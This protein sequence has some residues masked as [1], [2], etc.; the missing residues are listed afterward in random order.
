MELDSLVDLLS[1]AL[2]RLAVARGE[3]GIVAESATTLMTE[4]V[5][6]GEARTPVGT[7]ESGIDGELLHTM[8]EP[9][10]EIV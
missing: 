5:A 2:A 10:F 7:R 8:A 1:D 6:V 4:N 3:G 9:A